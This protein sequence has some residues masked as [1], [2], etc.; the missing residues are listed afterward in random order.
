MQQRRDFIKKASLLTGSIGLAGILPDSIQKAL[1]INPVPGSTYLDAEH[2]VFLMQENRSFDHTFGTLKGVR[3]FNNPRAIRLAND[4]P[5]WLQRNKKGETYTPFRLNIKDTRATWMSDL[6]HSW[7]NQV[8]AR[9]KGLHDGWLEAKRPGNKDYADMPLTMGYYNR[10]DIPFHYALADA[11]TVCDHHFCSSLTGTSSNRCFFWTGTIR[12]EQNARSKPHISNGDID[13][14]ERVSWKTYPERLSEHGV[15]WKV[16]QNELSVGTDLEGEAE[17]W[18]A[19]FTDNDLEFFKQ[20]HVRRHPEHL[21]YLRQ[22]KARIEAQLKDKPDASAQKKLDEIS[23]RIIFLEQNPLSSLSAEQQDLHKRAFV[24]NRAD[25]DYHTLETITYDDNGVSRT[26]RIPKGDV[27]HQF[28]ADVDAGRLPTVSWLVAPCNFSDHPGAPWYGAWYLSEAIDILTKNPEVWKKTIFVLTYDENDGYF[29]HMP[30]FVAPDPEDK[31]SGRVSDSLD[32]STEY[33][34]EGQ[35]SR[36]SPIGLGF[37]VPMVVVSPWTRGGYVNSEVFDHTSNIQF[38][39]KFLQHKTGKLIREENIS[40]WRRSV[41]GDLSSV[42]RPYHGEVLK[43]PSRL[44]RIPFIEQIHKAKFAKLPDG[45]KKLSDAE[46]TDIIKNPMKSLL[47]P[48]QEPGIKPASAI[49]YE[50]YAEAALTKDRS[51]IEL[52][53]TAGITFFGKRSSAGSFLVYGNGRQWPFT[54]AAG[55][56]LSHQ[57][58]LEGF[59]EQA[60][61]LQV[62]SVNG[63]YRRYTGNAQDPG[64]LINLLYERDNR[65]RPTGGVI[66]RATRT[67]AG[68]A[69]SLNISDAMYN[70]ANRKVSMKKG[71]KELLLSFDLSKAHHWYDINVTVDQHPGFIRHYGGHVELLK[72]SFTDPYMGKA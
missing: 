44:K 55:D 37:R 28:R 41:C 25:P 32:I 2:V 17:S 19:N 13:G 57:W 10:D 34:G 71:Q 47:L 4:Y 31:E 3:G 70:I 18:L 29:D 6:P 65:N 49:P 11:F 67:E 66:L 58:R 36:K 62:Y 21:V 68:A 48:R 43:G 52:R 9:N 45:F 69:L 23:E 26:V 24:T 7:E 63:F 20:Y 61:D 35:T 56:T 51:A 5:V 40:S 64:L 1:A 12:P 72:D 16:Y 30:P 39:E 8:D 59:R 33:A 38:L 27:F 60:Y 53:F 42:F 14:P 15:D 54:A 46:I 50:L 22:S